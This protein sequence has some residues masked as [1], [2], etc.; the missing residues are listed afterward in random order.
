MSDEK[1]RKDL[2]RL[3]HKKPELRK[4]L[5]PVLKESTNKTAA[6]KIELGA[7]L[8]VAFAVRNIDVKEFGAYGDG[9]SFVSGDFH[10]QGKAYWKMDRTYGFQGSNQKIDIAQFSTIANMAEDPGHGI[11]IN[12]EDKSIP[13]VVLT[14]LED[15]NAKVVLKQLGKLEY[16]SDIDTSW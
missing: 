12:I 13:N 3:A 7:T 11:H 8:V 5:L 6:N 10:I 9:D 1:L 15:N 16:V 2:I 4:D 14:A